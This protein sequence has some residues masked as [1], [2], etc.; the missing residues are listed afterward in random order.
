MCINHLPTPRRMLLRKITTK[1]LDFIEI[2]FFRE[3]HETT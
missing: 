2:N 3:V 1:T